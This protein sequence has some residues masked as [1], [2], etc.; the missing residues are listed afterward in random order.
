M[1][2]SVLGKRYIMINGIVVVIDGMDCVGKETLKNNLLQTCMNEFHSVSFPQYHKP[3]GQVVRE[4]M[5]S[6]SDN[7]VEEELTLHQRYK[8]L[9]HYTVD[10]LDFFGENQYPLVLCD[11]YYTANMLYQPLS[12]PTVEERVAFAQE[13][14]HIETEVFK[15]PKAD[16]V[17]I[18]RNHP[19][20]IQRMVV[21]RGNQTDGFESHKTQTKLHKHIDDLADY[22]D[23]WV[24]IDVNKNDT[25]M[26]TPEEVLMK[27]TEA[28]QERLGERLENFKL[29]ASENEEY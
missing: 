7:V 27:A 20:I 15:L 16:L 17:I 3:T 5:N 14:E 11:R 25:E 9:L 1:F 8:H 29:E 12:L 22:Y 10:R 2:G 24:I 26:Y 6:L 13:I 21:E 28:I 23:D 18:L 4:Y 19:D